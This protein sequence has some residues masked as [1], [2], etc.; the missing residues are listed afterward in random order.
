[1]I[2]FKNKK[3]YQSPMVELL[4]CRVERGYWMSGEGLEGFSNG[5]SYGNTTTRP[6]GRVEG[7]SNGNSYG[8]A[9]FN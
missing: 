7:F 4:E 8:G 9:K 5:N 2:K 3:K 6:G 1:M